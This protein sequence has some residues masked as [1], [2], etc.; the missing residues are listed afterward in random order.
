MYLLILIQE[1]IKANI[2]VAKIVLNPKIHVDPVVVSFKT[3]LKQDF[4]KTILANSITLTPGTI[5]INFEDDVYMIHCL[6][7][8]FAGGL[9]N[10]KFEEILLKI[11]GK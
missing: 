10:S 1:V 6:K 2:D 3:K 9:G 11:E 5:T 7:S 8:E 4:T